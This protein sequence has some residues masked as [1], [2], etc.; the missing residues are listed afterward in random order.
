MSRA[1]WSLTYNNRQKFAPGGFVHRSFIPNKGR[2]GM[3]RREAEAYSRAVFWWMGLESSLNLGGTFAYKQRCTSAHLLP[4]PACSRSTNGR[5]LWFQL[6]IQSAE[7]ALSVCSG[8][9]HC[10]HHWGNFI[11]KEGFTFN[12]PTNYNAKKKIIEYFRLDSQVNRCYLN[13]CGKKI[14]TQLKNSSTTYSAASD[15]FNF[16]L[17]PAF[18]SP[19]RN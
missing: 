8:F 16:T 18:Y 2:S 15:A 6:F 4:L 17:P 14:F 19:L 1:L 5:R 13:T 12:L 3:A 10:L 7:S 9:R 11:Q